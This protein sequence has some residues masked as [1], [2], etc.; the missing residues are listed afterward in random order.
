MTL[1]HGKRVRRLC[2]PWPKAF[3]GAGVRD[4]VGTGCAREDS[5]LLKP[6]VPKALRL[7]GRLGQG[8]K[9]RHYEVGKGSF[10]GAG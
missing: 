8:C 6:K 2:L 9:S 5:V 10:Q 3:F 1:E 7:Y 4:L